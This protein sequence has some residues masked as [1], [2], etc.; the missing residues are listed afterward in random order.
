VPSPE[1][2]RFWASGSGH[3]VYSV[4]DPS[5]ER[6]GTPRPLRVLPPHTRLR[7]KAVPGSCTAPHPY[8]PSHFA[9]NAAP[10][11]AFG[12]EC[13]PWPTQESRYRLPQPQA[14]SA[15]QEDLDL[16]RQSVFC[17]ATFAVFVVT[18]A[19]MAVSAQDSNDLSIRPT[20]TD[21]AAARQATHRNRH[22]TSRYLP[23]AAAAPR[24]FLSPGRRS[25]GVAA[26][27]AARSSGPPATRY[28]ADVTYQG[29]A[30]VET[31]ESRRLHASQRPL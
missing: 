5:H 15:F 8:L 10:E 13:R 9:T 7:T 30:V 25:N 24:T 31:A 29:G 12:A 22:A 4:V 14:T 18:F 11:A 6:V 28:P 17:V 19:P 3:R 27:A 21:R 23:G 1:V 16:C 2:T 26:A 20:A